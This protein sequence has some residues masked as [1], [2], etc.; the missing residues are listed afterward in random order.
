MGTQSPGGPN[1][2]RVAAGRRNR[3]LRRGLTPEGRERLRLSAIKHR[4]WRYSTGPKTPQGKARSAENG[5][6][7]QKGAV[8]KRELGKELVDTQTAAEQMQV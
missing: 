1:P 6:V 8:S 3:R 7:R 4:P 5:R 2:K